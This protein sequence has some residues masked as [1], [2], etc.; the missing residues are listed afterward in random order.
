TM[1]LSTTGS[2]NVAIGKD[3]GT[4][5]T[6]YNKCTFLGATADATVNNFTNA[7]AIGYGAKVSG[8]N[9][10]RVGN[11]AVTSIGGQVG[12]TTVSD[13]RLKE[14]INDSKLGLNFI[15]NLHPVT[16]NYKDEEQ[17]DILYTG[18]IAQEVDAAAK[19]E[20]VDFSGVDKNGEYWGIRYGDLTVP[21]VKGMQEL[22]EELKIRNEKLENKVS[23]LENMILQMQECLNSLCN[24]QQKI[25]TNN[26]S[27]SPQLSVSP[28]PSNSFTTI[29]ISGN[30][31]QQNLIVKITD[32]SGKTIRTFT[33]NSETEKFELNTTSFM[34]GVYL[35]Q[36]YNQNESIQTEK[37]IVQ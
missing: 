20:N 8:S 6:L 30:D 15:L 26:T 32:A 21:L 23:S 5:R 1:S 13:F 7:T 34:D 3:A 22:N 16:Y 36:L 4:L 37:L 18:L 11:T 25:N 17:R 12:W 9:K 29:S 28:N 35:I 24:N 14:N 27:S 10:V 2:N 19:K 33:V 31:K